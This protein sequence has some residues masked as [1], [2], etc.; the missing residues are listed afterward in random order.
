MAKRGTTSPSK[1]GGTDLQRPDQMLK[2][3]RAL[4]DAQR[5][6]IAG[7]TKGD[8]GRRGV[9]HCVAVLMRE[10]VDLRVLR[11]FEGLTFNQI[12]E[13]VVSVLRRVE[14]RLDKPETPPNAAKIKR[15]YR[16]SLKSKNEGEK[17]LSCL[18]QQH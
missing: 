15:Q 10:G 2:Y 3:S 11:Q 7:F 8:I 5:K 9:E 17:P 14:L 13:T 6:I 12:R 18:D 16:K 4:P 1:L